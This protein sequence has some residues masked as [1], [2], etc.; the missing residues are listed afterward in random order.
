MSNRASSRLRVNLSFC[1][2]AE[3]FACFDA[4]NLARFSAART[5]EALNAGVTVF[6]G[7]PQMHALL[8]QYTKEQGHD[9]L[10]SNTLRYT[11]SGAAPLDP[12]F[13]GGFDALVEERR[14]EADAFY[15][16]VLPAS[17]D[18]EEQAGKKHV[19]SRR[20]RDE[21]IESKKERK[22]LV[23]EQQAAKRQVKL[24]K[25]LKKKKEKANKK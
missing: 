13:G 4:P 23:K 22:K 18:D 11:S 15:A 2:R 19:S 3:R 8:M 16:A 24:K 1:C 7:V 25:H 14:G 12:A 10:P 6:S 5:Y 21:S 20:P 9:R 17:C